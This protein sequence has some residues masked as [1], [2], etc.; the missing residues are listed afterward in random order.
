MA[1]ILKRKPEHAA[2][3]FWGGLKNVWEDGKKNTVELEGWKEEM[4]LKTL[5]R[6]VFSA[7]H[8]PRDPTKIDDNY[9]FLMRRDAEYAEMA[10]QAE[11]DAYAN[12]EIVDIVDNGPSALPQGVDASTGE[13]RDQSADAPVEAA[14]QGM[15][16]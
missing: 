8:I 3:E 14:Q 16:F 12:A 11:L 10:R 13:V 2:A 9:R 5:K 7:K 15:D 1:D 4:Y 6:E